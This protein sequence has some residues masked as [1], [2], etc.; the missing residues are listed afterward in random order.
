MTDEKKSDYRTNQKFTEDGNFRKFCEAAGVNPSK[1][2]ASK[3][4]RGA[5]AAYRAMREQ[6]NG[7]A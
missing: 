2:Q 3:F 5:G 7:K 1:R 6:Y 4:R